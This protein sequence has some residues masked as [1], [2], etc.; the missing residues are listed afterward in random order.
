M[1]PLG[2]VGYYWSEKKSRKFKEDEFSNVCRSYGFELV[3]I[4]FDCPLDE[5][6]PF[7]AIV[8][9]LC[10]YIYNAD[11]G[12][13][14]SKS[15]C[16]AFQNYADK[17]PKVVVID[18]LPNIRTLLDRYNQYNCVAGELGKNGDFFIPAFVELTTTNVSENMAKMKAAGID[19]PILCKPSVAHGST[20]AHQMCL[21]FNE[22]G[23]KDI[24]P[25]CV[26][27]KFINHNAVLYKLF[28]I[29]DKYFMIERPSLKNF[30]AG[31]QKTIYFNSH[32]I[33]KPHSSSALNELDDNEPSTPFLFPDKEKMDY[34]VRVLYKC[35]RLSLLGI[36]FIIDNTTGNYAV[37]DINYF[38]GYD[39]VDNF[40]ELV[41]DMIVKKVSLRAAGKDE[42]SCKLTLAQRVTSPRV[43][44]QK[45]N[46]DSVKPQLCK[47]QQPR[48]IIPS[49][50]R[51]LCCP[52]SSTCLNG[53][54]TEPKKSKKIE[55]RLDSHFHSLDCLQDDSGIETSDSCDEK[56]E[57]CHRTMRRLHSRTAYSAV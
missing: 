50:P 19:F 6:G 28:T 15:V 16:E 21:V 31:D 9:K 5:Q 53:I 37:I 8:H 47:Q 12:D 46:F 33:S 43:N 34:I 30:S 45:F 7:V 17:H 4:D 18:P 38:P 36:D 52:I 25:P 44:L 41:C 42:S 20:L 14:P 39:E 49:I 55:S 48:A 23:L 57:T 29:G 3:K 11:N 51:C 13:L 27:Q 56:K 35:L 2:R 24:I 40:Y 22:D 32:D 10:N 54:H 1:F 26:A